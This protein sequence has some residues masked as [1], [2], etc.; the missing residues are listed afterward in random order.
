MASVINFG[1]EIDNTKSTFVCF[2]FLMDE[3]GEH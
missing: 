3:I 1:S 2:I